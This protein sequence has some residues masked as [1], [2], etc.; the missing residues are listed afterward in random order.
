MD[1]K[2]NL[3]PSQKQSLALGLS[4]DKRQDEECAKQLK[5]IQEEGSHE[6]TSVEKS[7]L[8]GIS[9]ISHVSLIGESVV[10]QSKM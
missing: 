10:S 4:F 2:S 8:S 3:E 7:K 1:L 5:R 6:Q 9:L